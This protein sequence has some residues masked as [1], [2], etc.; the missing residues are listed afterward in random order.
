MIRLSSHW[1]KRILCNRWNILR[2]L[3]RFGT[4]IRSESISQEEIYFFYKEGTN[5]ISFIYLQIKILSSNM[6]AIFVLE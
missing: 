4:L 5:N 3:L 6:I 1:V 2:Y